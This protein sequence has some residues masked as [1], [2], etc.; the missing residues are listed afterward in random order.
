[1]PRS[2]TYCQPLGVREQFIIP[3]VWHK[4]SHPSVDI[5]LLSLHS[6]PPSSW[7]YTF[8]HICICWGS[9]LLT[10][11]FLLVYL[12]AHIVVEAEKHS[13]GYLLLW[14]KQPLTKFKYFLLFFLSGRVLFRFFLSVG[15]PT[16]DAKGGGRPKRRR[17][18]L[19]LSPLSLSPSIRTYAVLMCASL[20]RPSL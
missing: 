14:A 4:H 7:I 6:F 3:S 9:F 20:L 17:T 5:C 16:F 19:F 13:E 11:S 15:D 18:D 2:Y 10:R 8:R 1:M 12:L